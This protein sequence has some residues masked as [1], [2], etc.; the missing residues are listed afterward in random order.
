MTEVPFCSSTMYVNVFPSSDSRAAW[1]QI[2]ERNRADY[3]CTWQQDIFPEFFSSGKCAKEV[4]F[5]C[6]F[7]ISDTVVSITFLSMLC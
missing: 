1:L 4:F 2:P 6:I 3:I 7:S 5:L